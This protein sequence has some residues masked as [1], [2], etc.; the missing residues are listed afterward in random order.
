MTG[1]SGFGQTNQWNNQQGNWAVVKGWRKPGRKKRRGQ[2]EM[3][4]VKTTK[5]GWLG[6]HPLL[7]LFVYRYLHA[8]CVPRQRTQ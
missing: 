8:H 6:S 2:E 1:V 3:E 4:F 5:R 7:H